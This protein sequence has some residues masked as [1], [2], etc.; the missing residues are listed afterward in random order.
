M[1]TIFAQKGILLKLHA[2]GLDSISNIF[3]DSGQY[4]NLYFESIG[5]K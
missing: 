5:G 2:E 1:M 4:K 3:G